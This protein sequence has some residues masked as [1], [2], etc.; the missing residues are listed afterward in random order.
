MTKKDKKIIQI[1]T[2]IGEDIDSFSINDTDEWKSIHTE[3]DKVKKD[4]PKNKSEV[5]EILN[6]CLSGLK[7]ISEKNTDDFL[8]LV[9]EISEA[10]IASEKY[11]ID[12]KEGK[13]LLSESGKALEGIL[14]K[15]RS[16]AGSDSSGEQMS[17][18]E[19]GKMSLNEVAVSLIQLEPDDS[20]GLENL[21]KSLEEIAS[22][23]SYPESSREY[24][25]SAAGKI[26][27]IIEGIAPDPDA[28]MEEVGE[29]LEEAMNSAG[30]YGREDNEKSVAAK[31]SKPAEDQGENQSDESVQKKKK[32]KIKETGVENSD[33]E[34]ESKENI[35]EVGETAEKENKQQP[36]NDPNYD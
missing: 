32:T 13:P 10:L 16:E 33:S 6:L 18:E 35:E 1:L 21:K 19:N 5:T 22:E 3:L 4:L 12:K 17:L 25:G 2:R 14:S 24:A 20:K 11:I 15:N 9:S 28:A 8:S 31:S 23:E 30:D 7:A 26:M 27:M 29:L 34:T 36:E